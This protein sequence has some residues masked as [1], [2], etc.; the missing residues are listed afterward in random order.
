VP[1]EGHRPIFAKL[2]TRPGSLGKRPVGLGTLN[3]M[4]QN[5]WLVRFGAVGDDFVIL[6]GL[7]SEWVT[8]AH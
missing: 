6:R 4:G 7:P 8:V 1:P 5:Q 3:S 2:D